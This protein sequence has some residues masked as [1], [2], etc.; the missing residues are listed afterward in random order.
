LQDTLPY[1]SL[2]FKKNKG[3][4]GQIAQEFDLDNEEVDWLRK[5]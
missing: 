4:S 2:I 3:L 5:N 1:L